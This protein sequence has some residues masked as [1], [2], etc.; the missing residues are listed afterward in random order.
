MFI[1]FVSKII[2]TVYL[3][4]TPNSQ[5]PEQNNIQH[6]LCYTTLVYFHNTSLAITSYNVRAADPWSTFSIKEG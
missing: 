4:L 6:I 3:W 2:F 5:V 1:K